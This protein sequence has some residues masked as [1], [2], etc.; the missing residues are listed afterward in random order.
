MFGGSQTGLA[1]RGAG[2]D[3]SLAAAVVEPKALSVAT[4]ACPPRKTIHN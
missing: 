1:W 2:R 3:E 4:L